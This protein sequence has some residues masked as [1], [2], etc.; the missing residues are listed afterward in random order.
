MKRVVSLMH[1]QAV[2]RKAEGLYFMVSPGLM[3]FQ[4]SQLIGDQ[5][6]TLYLFRSIMAEEKSLPKEQPYKDLVALINFI[7]RKFFKAVEEDSFLIVEV[8]TI[9]CATYTL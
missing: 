6:S 5:V 3:L 4:V 2:K 8:S 1:R 7:L 9:G